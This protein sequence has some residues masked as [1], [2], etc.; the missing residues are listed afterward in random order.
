MPFEELDHTADWSMHV[1]ARNLNQLFIDACK[2]MNDLS[3]I[4]LVREPRIE[5]KITTSAPDIDGLLVSFLSDIIYFIEKDHLAFDHFTVKLTLLENQPCRLSA[6]LSGAPIL[7]IGKV[8]K[9]VTYH[10]LQIQP[11]KD[12]YELIIVFDV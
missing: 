2:G 3:G 4:S 6:D 10:N 8:I 1:W 11:T 9:A 5:K 12:G 7:K